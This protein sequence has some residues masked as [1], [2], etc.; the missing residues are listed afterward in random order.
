MLP[1]S[2]AV[3]TTRGSPRGLVANLAVAEGTADLPSVLLSTRTSGLDAAL[4]LS[5]VA[6]PAAARALYD[7]IGASIDASSLAN[8]SL[9]DVV[10]ARESALLVYVSRVP[11]SELLEWTPFLYKRRLAALQASDVERASR[12]ADALVQVPCRCLLGSEAAADARPL[13]RVAPGLAGALATCAPLRAALLAAA[14]RFDVAE[15]LRRAV[16]EAADA[17]ARATTNLALAHQQLH[18]V[19]LPQLEA[20][21]GAA[22][23]DDGATWRGAC[24]EERLFLEPRF[25]L[26][27]GDYAAAMDYESL[28]RLGITHV[29]NCAVANLSQDEFSPHA[30]AISYAHVRSDDAHTAGAGGLLGDTHESEDPSPQWPAVIAHIRAARS[31]RGGCL[32]HCFAGINRSVTTAAVYLACD[33]LVGSFEEGVRA[34]QSVRKKAAP[35]PSYRAWGARFVAAEAAAG[36]VGPGSPAPGGAQ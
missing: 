27:V 23:A 15:V 29:V 24:E 14:D 8:P 22:G 19:P 6:A 3:L 32:V 7:V 33:G 25:R 26:F 16:L 35:L 12:L 34:I 30:P 5:S 10:D 20:A 1:V 31:A 36:R 11:T 28:R 9:F 13:L 4:R 17:R 18:E 2:V 21:G